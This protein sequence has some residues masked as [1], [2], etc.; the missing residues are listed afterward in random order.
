MKNY[1]NR[2]LCTLLI[3]FAIVGVFYVVL[4]TTL[5]VKYYGLINTSP[6]C[7]TEISSTAGVSCEEYVFYN[8][9]FNTPDSSGTVILFMNILER[10]YQS[11][12]IVLL[13][14]IIMLVLEMLFND[15]V[16]DKEKK[17]LLTALLSVFTIWI[18]QGAYY[19]VILTMA[20][21]LKGLIYLHTKKIKRNK[22]ILPSIL[23]NILVP[24]AVY[25]VGL[26]CAY[27]TNNTT[28]YFL[29]PDIDAFFSSLVISIL[30]TGIYY[31]VFSFYNK[32]IK[33]NKKRNKIK[34]RS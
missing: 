17:Y 3:T 31:L 15:I 34:T 10:V 29:Y 24:I 11:L 19:I 30:T 14:F 2:F 12:S 8:K 16:E 21:V 7:T 9:L 5:S 18:S 20:L 1:F 32:K 33:K 13:L 28:Q 6:L 4:G 22:L 26:V 25:V 23:I 27:L